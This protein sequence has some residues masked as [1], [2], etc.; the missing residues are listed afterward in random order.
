MF[1]D[2]DHRRDYE[3]RACRHLDRAGDAGDFRQ[4]PAALARGQHAPALCDRHSAG[5]DRK[6]ACRR[7]AAAAGGGRRSAAASE[8]AAR[9]S[10][11]SDLRGGPRPTSAA[12]CSLPT[13]SGWRASRR[14]P[15]AC[16]FCTPAKRIPPMSQAKQIIRHVFEEAHEL[17]SG[18]AAHRLPGR[19]RMAPGR[20]AHRRRGSVAEQSAASL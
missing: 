16:R 11:P 18:S 10:S 2:Y 13:R 6:R 7:Q 20:A 1:P 14:T 4:A 17:T 3:W 15:A 9:T 12:T 19:L 8:A 5:R